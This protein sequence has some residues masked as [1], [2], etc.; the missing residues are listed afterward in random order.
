MVNRRRWFQVWNYLCH[1]NAWIFKMQHKIPRHFKLHKEKALIL[2]YHYFFTFR[3]QHFE[4]K[5]K[6]GILDFGV[7][8]LGPRLWLNDMFI[9]LYLFCSWFSMCVSCVQ[10]VGCDQILGSKASLD[11][12]GICKGDNSTCKFFKGQYTLQHRANG[13]PVFVFA[14]VCSLASM[15]E[16]S[17]SARQKWALSGQIRTQTKANTHV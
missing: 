8:R 5:L 12:C 11:A 16:V 7:Q 4:S 10:A 3:T 13:K 2:K 17:F 9:S 1:S 15:N 6:N 14:R